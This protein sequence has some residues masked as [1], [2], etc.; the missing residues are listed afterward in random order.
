MNSVHPDGVDWME[1][2][3]WLTVWPTEGNVSADVLHGSAGFDSSHDIPSSQVLVFEA[4]AR[5]SKDSYLIQAAQN[6][7]SQS[8]PSM[9]QEI[10]LVLHLDTLSQGSLNWDWATYGSTNHLFRATRPTNVFSRV[11]NGDR[12]VVAASVLSD[13]GT[14]RALRHVIPPDIP[15]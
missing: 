15:N 9:C 5:L 10:L 2:G 11:L 3:Q 1:V 8:D 12:Q 13:L 6:P 4:H 14:G 7:P